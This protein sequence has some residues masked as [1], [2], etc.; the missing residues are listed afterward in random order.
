MLKNWDFRSNLEAQGSPVLEA[1]EYM[2]ATYMHET[3]IEDVRFRRAMYTYPA[4]E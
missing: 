1:W 4:S 3:T 2:L